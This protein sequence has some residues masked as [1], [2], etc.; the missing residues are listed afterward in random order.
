MPL[1]STYMYVLIAQKNRPRL[2][3]CSK[4]VS[5]RRFFGAPTTCFVVENV[6]FSSITFYICFGCSEKH[7]IGCSKEVSFRRFFGAPTTICFG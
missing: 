3:D 2:I 4:E 6:N 1:F 5:L 7:L